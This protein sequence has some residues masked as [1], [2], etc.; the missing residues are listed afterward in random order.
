M[1]DLAD[2]DELNDMIGDMARE[3]GR[4]H[5]AYSPD[6]VELGEVPI[7]IYGFNS[8]F[9]PSGVEQYREGQKWRRKA[10][11]ELK[12]RPEWIAEWR[13]E[14]DLNLRIKALCKSKGLNVYP[15]EI[16]PWKAPDELPA[17]YVQGNEFISSAL[18]SLPSA[19]KLRRQLIAELEGGSDVP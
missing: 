17:D 2:P 10:L 9:T 14:R 1:T 4:P 15:W 6:L 12:R 7:G 11:D 19:V 3:L 8:G 13:A 5:W 16:P 18:T